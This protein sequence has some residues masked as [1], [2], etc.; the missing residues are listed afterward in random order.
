MSF[1][2]LK[3]KTAIESSGHL[4]FHLGKLAGLIKTDA[5]GNYA[6]TD[7]GREALHI[8]QVALRAETGPKK[9]GMSTRFDPDPAIVGISIVWAIILVATSIELNGTEFNSIVVILGGGF[10]ACLLILARF[11]RK[12]VHLND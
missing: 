8:A 9:G 4:Q 11:G 7:Q 5:S 1:S 12:P 6:L 2:E 10:V 3:W